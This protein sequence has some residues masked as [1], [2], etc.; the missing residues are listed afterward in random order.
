M[1]ALGKTTLT[2]RG[3]AAR[4]IGYARKYW[5]W[6]FLAVLTM[7]FE[8]WAD[9]MIPS[10]MSRLVDDGILG[11]AGGGPDAGAIARYGLIMAAVAAAGAVAGVLNNLFVNLT[12]QNIGNDIRKSAFSRIM[13]MTFPQIEGYTTGSLITRMTNDVS[14]VQRMVGNI[15]RGCVKTALLL[16]GSIWFVFQLDRQFGLIVLAAAPLMLLGMIL[17]VSKV[18]PLFPKLQSELDRVN[19]I[20]QEDTD[21]I[22]VIKSCVRE[23]HEIARFGSA[24]DAL[25]AIQLRI[26]TIFACIGPI[27]NLILA[28]V[29]T[30][31]LYVGFSDA[32]AGH[33]SPGSV[34]AGIMYTTRLL[35][36]V[37]MSVMLFQMISR[38]L[39]SWSRLREI[40]GTEPGMRQG[41]LQSPPGPRG[42]VEV[43]GVS[44]AFPDTL[45]PVL[46]DVSLTVRPGESVAVMGATGCGKTSLVNLIARLYDPTAGEVLVSGADVRSYTRQAL[47]SEVCV[48]LQKPELFAASIAQNIAWGDPGASMDRIREAARIAQ[49][50]EFILALPEGYDTVI[51]ED[52]LSLSGGQRQ[53]IALARAVLRRAPVL[54]LDDA[55]SAL[56]LKTE[57][58]FYRALERSMPDVT[59][60]IVAQ[61]IATARR[62]DRIAL[63]DSERIVAQG[64][65][66]ELLRSC[67]V[68]AEIF[69]SQGGASDGV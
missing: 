56:D 50:E 53:R 44:F 48:A 10:V 47:V 38:G 63:I 3:M 24:S 66:E 6:A 31:M 2:A 40:L 25:I 30:G 37:M 18:V 58:L 36:S 57:A 26:L 1:V 42:L 59:R 12:G 28:A 33:G 52:G 16:A 51:A 35:M 61:R 14:Q 13:Q 49:A 20:L 19:A 41:T 68:Y 22:R 39:T 64:T 15:V 62:A 54:I 43:R 21:A 9:L 11:Q 29:V 23:I 8:V 46:T 60:I 69:K 34:M 67:P 4:M 32:L 65:H 7:G 27:M 45:E 5:H 55:T 17:C